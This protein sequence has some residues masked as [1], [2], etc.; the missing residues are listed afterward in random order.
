VVLIGALRPTIGPLRQ[1]EVVEAQVEHVVAL[2]VACRAGLVHAVEQGLEL[3]PG[4]RVEVLGGMFG[5][6]S[7][8]QCPQLVDLEHLAHR[9]LS[10]EDPAV[11]HGLHQPDA[12]EHADRFADRPP[13][14]AHAQRQRGLVQALAGGDLAAVDHLLE[15]VADALREPLAVA[16]RRCRGD[17]IRG[18]E[19]SCGHGIGC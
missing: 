17:R 13:A 15:L 8:Q 18:R 1:H 16:W 4:C 11:A 6:L 5:R 3:R 19:A 9:D 14:G 10:H 12:G 2:P 7:E